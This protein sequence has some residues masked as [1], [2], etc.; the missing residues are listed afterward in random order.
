MCPVSLTRM[1]P[2]TIT[3][4]S[5]TIKTSISIFSKALTISHTRDK[6]IVHNKSIWRSQGASLMLTCRSTANEPSHNNAKVSISHYLTLATKLQVLR[7]EM[8]WDVALI[9]KSVWEN[10]HLNGQ[11][12]ASATWLK[13]DTRSA[14]SYVEWFIYC[15]IVIKSISVGVDEV[16][17][18]NNRKI[19]WLRLVKSYTLPKY[20]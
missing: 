5:N 1:L 7:C 10:M 3:Q 16:T 19:I 17:R 11:K 4:V 20:T 2:R 14:C 13:D 18:S 6:D 12:K 15:E 8:H 9:V